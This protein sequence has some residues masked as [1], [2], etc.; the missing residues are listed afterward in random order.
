M[1]ER[2]PPAP[3]LSGSRSSRRY[4]AA[5]A[6]AAILNAS[7]GVA[8][9]H[10]G[11]SSPGAG[12]ESESGD[13]YSPSKPAPGLT[14]SSSSKK[15]FSFKKNLESE[16]V[17]E[18]PSLLRTAPS[19]LANIGRPV[20]SR[21]VGKTMSVPNIK[22]MGV[23]PIRTSISSQKDSAQHL[24]YLRIATPFDPPNERPYSI[25]NV[26]KD[27]EAHVKKIK[28]QRQDPQYKYVSYR[29][30]FAFFTALLD[31]LIASTG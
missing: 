15:F 5:Q 13:E 12:K 25:L 29:S 14:R 16:E 28:A 19:A 24:M 8:V 21:D 1:R 31:I 18:L 4:A 27:Y 26:A 9:N 6:A 17:K 3:K 22:N 7:A 11:T 2:T 20:R 23:R 10:D 30:I